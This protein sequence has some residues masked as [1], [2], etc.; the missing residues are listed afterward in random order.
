MVSYIV[1]GGQKG[2]KSR[3]GV[4][5]ESAPSIIYFKIDHD[6]SSRT[7]CARRIASQLDKEGDNIFSRAPQNH[8]HT[9]L[10]TVHSAI[11]LAGL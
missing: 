11:D 8:S 9:V 6:I 1:I 5:W 7:M 3:M 10:Y 4:V 2:K